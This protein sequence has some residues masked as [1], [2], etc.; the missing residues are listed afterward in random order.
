MSPAWPSSTPGGGAG[1]SNSELPAQPLLS[2]LYHVMPLGPDRVLIANGGRSVV[3]SG[4]GIARHVLPLL[5]ALDGSVPLD[6][7]G[8]RFPELVPDVLQGLAA[9][10]LLLEGS[11]AE[12]QLSGGPARAALALGHGAPGKAIQTLAG[13][14]VAVMGCGPVGSTVATLLAKANVGRL[15]LSD[16]KRPSAGEAATSPV[17]VGG[18]LGA[19]R[20]EAAR[21]LCTSAGDVRAEV[22]PV[23]WKTGLANEIDLAV[24]EVCYEVGD[25]P[26]LDA[27]ACLQTGVPYLVHGQDA[28]EAV[29]GPFVRPPASPCHCCAQRR[30]SSN[31]DRHDEYVA[32]RL[33]RAETAPGPDAFLAAH[34]AVV[35]GVVATQVLEALLFGEPPCAR[36]ALAID[37]AE[38]SIERE[39]VLP[40]PGCPGCDGATG[41]AS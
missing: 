20:A 22:A 32:Y 17:L 14:T 39:E 23:P 36:G 40:V 8:R 6:D 13:A 16:A 28:L 1:A 26:S 10:G 29:V 3:L 15:V 31:V 37:L 19:T 4:E 2:G 11:G 30:R 5:E 18:E 38:M 12:E 21:A 35:A 33:H 7:L 25:R 41:V 9:K 34:S 24:V 27:D